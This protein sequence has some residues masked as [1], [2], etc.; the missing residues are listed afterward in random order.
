M[1]IAHLHYNGVNTSKITL[2]LMNSARWPNRFPCIYR[3][4]CVHSV[5][6]N[7]THHGAPCDPRNGPCKSREPAFQERSCG[8]PQ[9]LHGS[10]CEVAAGTVEQR[11]IPAKCRRRIPG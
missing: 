11:Y 4:G 3:R 2:N 5:A 9:V 7:V 1:T 6:S 8:S 10:V